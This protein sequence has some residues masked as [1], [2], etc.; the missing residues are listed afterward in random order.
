MPLG[1]RQRHG[2]RS[3]RRQAAGAD[4]A[5]TTKR[6]F[7]ICNAFVRGGNVI[8]LAPVI[9]I[10]AAPCTITYMVL[11]ARSDDGRLSTGSGLNDGF[12]EIARAQRF[13]TIISRLRPSA[14]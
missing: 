2:P 4:G 3:D 14:V 11:A 1:Q 13:T 6:R 10:H 9:L 12:R 8:R 5:R 7:R